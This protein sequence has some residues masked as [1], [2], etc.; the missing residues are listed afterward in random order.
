M[1]GLPTPSAALLKAYVI[2]SARHLT[3]AGAG[4]DLPGGNQGFGLADMDLGFDT[5]VSR[6][7][8]DQ[9][10]VFGA[11]AQ[12]ATFRGVIVDPSRPVRVALVWT[13][14]PGATFGAAFV[15]DLNLVVTID[16]TTYRGNNFML[17]ESQPGGSPDTRNNAE[18]V[19]LSPGHAGPTTITVQATTIAGD[20]V[21]GNADV[22]DQDFALVAY[23]FAIAVPA[24]A[25]Y[26]D[27]A[28]YACAD[29][30][31]IVV[32]D[33][34][35]AGT[36]ALSVALTTSG[37]DAETTSLAEDPPDSGVFTGAIATTGA[38]VS[39]GDG[40]LQV[41]EGQTITATYNDADDGTGHPATVHASAPVIACPRWSPT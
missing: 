4:E 16:G 10:T 28:A 23:N 24:G 32:G 37:G 9:A 27:R 29:T 34:N 3:G 22:T 14:A 36:G 1:Y 25:I 2:H 40:L 30:L 8:H 21:P 5:S 15:N 6:F 7:F 35:L 26:F 11:S 12:S 18:A 17:G 38:A 20:G 41:A 33:S 39:A 13:D 31:R 19:F